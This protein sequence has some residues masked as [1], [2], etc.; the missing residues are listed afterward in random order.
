MSRRIPLS[1]PVMA[2]NEWR[3]VKE[4]IDTAWVSSAGKFI[5]AFAEKFAE[6]VDIPYAVPVVNGTAALH[7][8]LVALGL[9]SDEEVLVPT[10]TFAA[11]ANV[12]IYCNANPVFM[13]VE[14][15][16][17][18]IDPQKVEAFLTQ[19]CDWRDGCLI[20]RATN[21]KVRGIIPVHLYGHPVDMSPILDLAEKYNLFVVED[22]TEALG[23][24]YKGRSAGTLGTVGAFSFNG[25]KLITT[26]GG[27]MVVTENSELAEHI[28]YLTTQAKA[29]GPVYYHTEVGYNYRMTNIQAAMGLAQLEK[30]HEFVARR[31]AIAHYYQQE[32]R[33]VAG[34][35]VVSEA[36]WAWN[37]HWLSWI[38]VEADYGRP[39]DE[40]LKKLGDKGIEARAFFMPLHTLPPY[41]SYQSYQISN[42]IKLYDKG[43]NVPSHTALVEDDLKFVADAVKCLA[44]D[45]RGDN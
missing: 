25:N 37:N 16:S 39:K 36:E 6:Y 17:L 31:R 23:S 11:T 42:A 5:D 40:L 3:Y 4:C 32:L 38:L 24:R 8:S 28:K 13:D 20:N 9:K 10:L 44:R 26:G 12:V 34:I 19:E 33:D 22:A 14:D 7:I 45:I 21:R 2:G 43:I 15:G 41:R 30:V 29:P 1:E 35:T 27:G 18:G